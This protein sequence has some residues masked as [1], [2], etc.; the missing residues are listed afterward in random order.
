MCVRLQV[1]M[2]SSAA[3]FAG[4]MTMVGSTVL[5]TNSLALASSGALPVLLPGLHLAP[6]TLPGLAPSPS[7]S[8]LSMLEFPSE[9]SLPSRAGFRGNETG[10][11]MEIAGEKE[12]EPVSGNGNLDP[13]WMQGKSVVDTIL[14]QLMAVL[15]LKSHLVQFVSAVSDSCRSVGNG[16]H[17][18]KKAQHFRAG[19]WV[20][21]AE[22]TKLKDE[23]KRSPA[24]AVISRWF[25]MEESSVEVDGAVG[26][27][28]C[29]RKRKVLPGN[30]CEMDSG[31]MPSG[32][33]LQQCHGSRC[34]EEAMAQRKLGGSG[35]WKGHGVRQCQVECQGYSCGA[36]AHPGGRCSREAS[37]SMQ[38]LFPDIVIGFSTSMPP[39]VYAT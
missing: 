10:D 9:T 30:G 33:S 13:S 35:W 29:C 27:C 37:A 25:E 34:W 19:G 22:K 7:L 15:T 6:A 14:S 36:E 28:P 16:K 23:E 39:P 2:V 38:R 3:Y 17:L 8:P 32:S 12:S 24:D 4:V 11:A 5:V 1:V 18:A 20:R 31:F 26:S 21:S